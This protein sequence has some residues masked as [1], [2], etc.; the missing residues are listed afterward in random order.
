MKFEL[1]DQNRKS[2]IVNACNKCSFNLGMCELLNQ[3]VLAQFLNIKK[4]TRE[5]LQPVR[6]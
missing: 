1:F 5:K 2:K 6:F 4:P 3:A